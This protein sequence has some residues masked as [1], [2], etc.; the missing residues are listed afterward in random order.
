MLILLKMIIITSS[1]FL[2]TGCFTS[3]GGPQ[4]ITNV[5]QI[6][7]ENQYTE[8][9]KKLINIAKENK[10]MNN[11]YIALLNSMK[12]NTKLYDK[13]KIPK[14]LARRMTFHYE[15]PALTL[16]KTIAEETQYSF[17]YNSYRVYDSKNIVRY[18]KDTMLIDIL[19]DIANELSF[20]VVIDEKDDRISLKEY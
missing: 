14:R 10:R 20:D 18:Y 6:K 19:Y 5:I 1:L 8:L 13:T 9:E 11:E 2:F 16:L 15:G 3:D 17:D 7:K 12:K 4:K